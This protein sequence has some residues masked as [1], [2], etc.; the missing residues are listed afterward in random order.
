[1][2]NA[3]DLYTISVMTCSPSQH[4]IF[5]VNEKKDLLVRGHT[6]VFKRHIFFIN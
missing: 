3:T 1:M 4:F 6:S 5:M 2:L